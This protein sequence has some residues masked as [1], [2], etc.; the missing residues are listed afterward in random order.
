MGHSEMQ[1]FFGVGGS[2][3]GVPAPHSPSLPTKYI[4]AYNSIP[5]RFPLIASPSPLW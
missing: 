2:R 1:L 4:D 3:A 5:T